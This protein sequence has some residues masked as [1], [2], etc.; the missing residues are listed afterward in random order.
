MRE[1]VMRRRG[2]TGSSCGAPRLVLV[3]GSSVSVL[4]GRSSVSVLVGVTVSGD[5][6]P[7]RHNILF[8]K[9]DQL[10]AQDTGPRERGEYV[11]CYCSHI[12]V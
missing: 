8:I 11:A 10:R 2:I 3:G 7:D 1:D 6:T 5:S 12:P 9:C 4:V